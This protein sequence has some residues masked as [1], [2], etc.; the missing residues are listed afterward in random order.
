MD[1]SLLL[2]EMTNTFEGCQL[3]DNSIVVNFRADLYSTQN[4][5]YLSQIW[6]T[7]VLASI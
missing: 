6:I 4:A 3:V 1:I 7:E 5:A 2:S